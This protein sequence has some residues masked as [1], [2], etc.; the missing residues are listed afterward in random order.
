MLTNVLQH[1]FMK[2]CVDLAQL[3]PL[4]RAAREARAQEKARKGGQ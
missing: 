4:V 1:E 2:E 3:S